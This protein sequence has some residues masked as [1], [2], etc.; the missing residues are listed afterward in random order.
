MSDNRTADSNGASAPPGMGADG[1]T[2]ID[3]TQVGGVSGMDT[4]DPKGSD[5]HHT[6][7][8]NQEVTNV[9]GEVLNDDP[10]QVDVGGPLK[11]EL[12]EPT[13]TWT[14]GRGDSAGQ[15]DPVTNKGLDM[16]NSSIQRTA[17]MLSGDPRSPVTPGGKSNVDV[18]AE[19]A[20]EVGPPTSTW[21]SDDF[22]ITD[23]VTNEHFPTDGVSDSPE[24]THHPS[25]KAP[26]EE[27]QSGQSDPTGSPA[28]HHDSEK[29][30]LEGLTGGG[31]ATSSVDIRSHILNS[32]K[33]A[34][35]ETMLGLTSPKEK[36]ARAAE[37]ERETPSQLNARLDSYTRVR[38]AGLRRPMPQRQV[39][40]S[41]VPAMPSLA[42][43]TIHEASYEGTDTFDGE[44]AQL[45]M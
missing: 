3:V 23:P 1:L 32:M 2:R 5:D 31:T 18:A 41:A 45:F 29:D 15:H 40:A 13:S 10:P 17:L 37:L 35:I 7:L 43:A 14:P 21:G 6:R 11:Q 22:H 38:Q 28:R 39:A 19:L 24:A 16:Y 33:I 26:L 4:V 20:Q 30:S 8:V 25:E 36:F 12:G 9:G 27:L 44:A 34:E 42:P